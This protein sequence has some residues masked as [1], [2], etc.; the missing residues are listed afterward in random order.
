MLITRLFTAVENW[1]QPRMVN[2]R[3]DTKNCDL[4]TYT[5]LFIYL[6]LKI[7]C[8]HERHRDRGRDTGRGRIRFHVGSLMWT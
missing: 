6:F 7:L 3:V 4:P 8:V 2:R 5:Y 1:E